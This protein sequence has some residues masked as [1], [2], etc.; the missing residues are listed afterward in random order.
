[1]ETNTSTTINQP[2]MVETL[3]LIWKDL[4]DIIIFLGIL[5]FLYLVMKSIKRFLDKKN[6]KIPIISYV[7]AAIIGMF[8][9]KV[10][11]TY[12]DGKELEEGTSEIVNAI[13]EDLKKEECN[14]N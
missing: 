2:N 5:V 12:K 6:I 8:T 9:K 10:T 1:M 14:E 7:F 11:S 3:D 4:G 13:K